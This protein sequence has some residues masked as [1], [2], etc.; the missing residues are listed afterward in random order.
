MKPK[1]SVTTAD[2][3]AGAVVESRNAAAVSG[4]ADG[5]SARVELVKRRGE[6][7]AFRKLWPEARAEAAK[8]LA[9]AKEAV[10]D[11]GGMD[12]LTALLGELGRR[13]PREEREADSVAR[14]AARTAARCG[15]C[16]RELGPDAIVF[17]GVEVY[18]GIAAL[19]LKPRHER[20]TVCE[21]CAPPFMS[22]RKSCDDW[23]RC[24]DAS[25]GGC[26]RPVVFRSSGRDLRR[27]AVFCSERCR[28]TCYNHWRNERAARA[29]RK[30]CEVCEEPFTASRQDARTCSA[31]CKQKAYR[32]RKGTA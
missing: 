9:L 2:S 1:R 20:T 7:G 26:G 29:R 16:G 24:P 30:V 28:W 15:R 3:P 21:A 5:D 13:R 11:V 31:A 10:G 23:R 8:S 18:V 12:G 14:E 22:R 32:R 6:R 17:L 4:A 27:R 25:C 19:V